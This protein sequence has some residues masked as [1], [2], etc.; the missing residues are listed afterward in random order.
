LGGGCHLAGPGAADF[1]EICTADAR[2]FKENSGQPQG[3]CRADALICGKNIFIFIKIFFI[4]PF[5]GNFWFFNQKSRA[6]LH[7]PE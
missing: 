4:F 7:F 5:T 1:E 3:I 2:I 6:A